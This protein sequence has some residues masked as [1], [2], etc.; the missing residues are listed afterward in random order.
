MGASPSRTASSPSP[1]QRSGLLGKG[2]SGS[3]DDVVD[4]G[5]GTAGS[6][7]RLQ[8]TA[9]TGND[10]DPEDP[11][12]AAAGLRSGDADGG[13]DAY[14]PI[15]T[16][17]NGEASAK[18]KNDGLSGQILSIA[19]PALVALSVDPLMS[20]VD[21]AYIGRLAA[22][23]GGGEIGLGA[24]ALNTNV[25]TFSFYIF[26]FLATVPTPFVASA[27]AK[28]DEKGAARLIGQLLTAALALGVVLLVL[29]EFFG[30]HLLQLLGATAVNEDQGFLDTKTP[31]LIGLAANGL[32]FVLDPILIF[33]FGW[34]LQ[35]AAI[36]TVTAEW[37]GVMA[38]LVLLAQKEPSIRLRPV[39][40]PKNREGWKEGSAVLTSSAA[41]FGRT[42]ALQGALGTATAFAA[43]VGPTAIAA[44]QV[45]NQLYLLLAFAADSL[46]VAAQGLVADRLGGGMVAEGREVAGRLIVFGLGLGVGTL[47]I[48][49]VFGGV[50]P[51][52][53]TSDQ[54]VI[55]AIAPVIAVVG[56]LQPLNGY[57]FVGDGILQGTQ[58]FVYERRRYK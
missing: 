10:L 19:V 5:Y 36:A 22:E 40:L 12:A 46:A 48:F 30:V 55:A 15:G 47:V 1:Q 35:G 2:V 27:R 41:V 58:D 31:L 32:N 45:C 28:G 11:S 37:A 43:R 57:V 25:F 20:A 18:S 14:L 38:F 34:G 49:Q 33:Q 56:L 4:D 9:P 29:L 53:F 17:G 50:L 6:S 24:L 21:T 26:N 16:D 52:I 7:T 3:N 13:I 54:K 44:H 39:S 23:H 51:L 42:V 8:A